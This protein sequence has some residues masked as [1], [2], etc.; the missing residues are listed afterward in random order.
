MPHP[1]GVRVRCARP[2]PPLPQR[3]LEM[4]WRYKHTK[5]RD[6]RAEPCSRVSFH[7]SL[8]DR[9][10]RNASRPAGGGRGMQ[11]MHAVLVLVLVLVLAMRGSVSPPMRRVFSS[12]LTKPSRSASI[13]AKS[14]CARQSQ[15][16]AKRVGCGIAPSRFQSAQRTGR[17]N[18]GGVAAPA[19]QPRAPQ[20]RS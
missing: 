16:P 5:S 19:S 20:H 14:S 8:H 17:R 18:T 4:N 2:C 10:G 1:D 12:T 9:A 15:S 6:K 11:T 3:T 13:S 7:A